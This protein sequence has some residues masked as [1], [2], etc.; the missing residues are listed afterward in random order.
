M[1]NRQRLQQCIDF[2][3]VH[4]YYTENYTQNDELYL[5]GVWVY[6]FTLTG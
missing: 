3:H 2:I 6:A 1:M 5:L 4:S